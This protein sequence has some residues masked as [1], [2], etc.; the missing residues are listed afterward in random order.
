[1]RETSNFDHLSENVL[2]TGALGLG[3][4]VAWTSQAGGEHREKRGYIVAVIPARESIVGDTSAPGFRALHEY[5]AVRRFD[6]GLPR[7][8]ESY[9]VLVA[10][11]SHRAKPRVYYPR[12]RALKRAKVS[13]DAYRDEQRRKLSDLIMSSGRV[14]VGVDP[15]TA[16]GDTTGVVVVKNGEVTQMELV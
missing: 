9:L 15:G 12:V 11:P 5:D 3:H 10:G 2:K 4:G 6:G 14:V 16:Q 7:K 1:M 8:H 13:L